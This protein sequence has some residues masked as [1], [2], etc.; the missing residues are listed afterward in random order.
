MIQ[1]APSEARWL[2][3]AP[4]RTLSPNILRRILET[5]FPGCSAVDVQPLADGFRNANFRIRLDSTPEFVVLRMYEHDIS[6]CRKEVDL[7]N[8]IRHSVP[9]P[10]VLHA[11]P[12]GMNDI[13]P[14]VLLSYIDGIAFRELTRHGNADSISQAAY[15]VGRTLA[16]IGRTTFPQPGWLGPGPDV[17]APL[18]KGRNLG[19]RFVDLCLASA[20]VRAR[21]N[22]RLRNQVSAL[23]WSCATQL[24]SMENET[25]LVHG[26]YGRR[27]LLVRK[28]GENWTVAAVLDWEFAVAGSPLTDVGHFLRYETVARPKVEPYFSNGYQQAGGRL[29][30]GWRRLARIMD[31]M[32]LCESLTHDAL[33][34]R[35]ITE[36]VELL[37]ATVED[38]DPV[39]HS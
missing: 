12:G 19:P 37:G 32:A 25:N 17:T 36:L 14:F 5:A 18:L 1:G 4:S 3:P 35:V 29:A 6:L 16:L 39:L 8:S 2:R 15:D 38:R 22:A 11:E 20:N 30:D 23:V 24:A 10:E 34:A 7:L 21:V 31:L 28:V 33:P 13:P 26:D 27:N 9:V